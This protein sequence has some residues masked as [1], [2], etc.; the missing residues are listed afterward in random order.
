MTFQFIVGGST[1][2]DVLL[3]DQPFA[4]VQAPFTLVLDTAGLTEGPH[5]VQARAGQ[6]FSDVRLVTVD[7]TPPRVVQR[8]P[9]AAQSPALR[10]PIEVEFNEPLAADSVRV[11]ASLALSADARRI[12]LVFQGPRPSTRLPLTVA[13]SGVTDLAGNVASAEAWLVEMLPFKRIPLA[14]D[15][16]TE[17]LLIDGGGRPWLLGT[18]ATREVLLTL[19]EGQWVDAREGI[20]AAARITDLRTTEEGTSSWPPSKPRRRRAC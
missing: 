12:T 11:D 4:T 18:K 8:S 6:V 19:R 14:D 17:K 7:R 9:L 5:R 3:D 13:I 20:P 1:S 2:I 16:F 15:V 10:T